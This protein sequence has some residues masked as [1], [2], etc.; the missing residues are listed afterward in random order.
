MDYARRA[1]SNRFML[2]FRLY[3]L[4][5]SPQPLQDNTA[6]LFCCEAPESFVHKEASPTFYWGVSIMTEFLFLAEG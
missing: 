5:K 6:K 1:V 2:F 4:K 3:T